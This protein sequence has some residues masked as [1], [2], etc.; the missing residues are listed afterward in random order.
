MHYRGHGKELFDSLYKLRHSR[1]SL[2]CLPTTTPKACVVSEQSICRS[3]ALP[4]YFPRI[5][6]GGYPLDSGGCRGHSPGP[7]LFHSASPDQMVKKNFPNKS[8]K[9]NYANFKKIRSIYSASEE[10]AWLTLWLATKNNKP[11][12][13]FL[14]K[15]LV[16]HI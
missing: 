1:S 3:L 10:S 2:N 7:P 4:P 15:P 16:I 5:K 14:V 8:P 9:T 12:F 11:V 13:G 6:Y